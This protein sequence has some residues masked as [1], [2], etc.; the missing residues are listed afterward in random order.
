MVRS[1]SGAPPYEKA[2]FSLS[3][4]WPGILTFR[5]RGIDISA[6]AFFDA[7][8]RIRIIVSE[9]CPAFAS[10]APLARLSEPIRRSVCGLPGSALARASFGSFRLPLPNAFAIRSTWW[11]PST[12][13][14]L[15]L[16]TITTIA[17]TR[18]RFQM[19]R[20]SGRSGNAQVGGAAP[21]RNRV[22]VVHER[23]LVVH[24]RLDRDPLVRAVVAGARGAELD[25]GSAG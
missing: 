14:A 7:S 25:A 11:M 20:L 6:I 15:A 9:R 5:S 17:P 3:V 12:V 16:A 23:A 1:R 24:E 13:V 8:S 18:K 4:P 22:D 10:R 2:A 21:L 19:P